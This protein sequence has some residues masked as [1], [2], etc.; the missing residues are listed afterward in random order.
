MSAGVERAD[1]CSARHHLHPLADAHLVQADVRRA[2]GHVGHRRR[3]HRV[4]LRPWRRPQLPHRRAL[5]A[6][7]ARALRRASPAA[8]LE[9]AATEFTPSPRPY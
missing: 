5:P 1:D 6:A 7:D 9:R 3:L 8:P 2:R 4:C